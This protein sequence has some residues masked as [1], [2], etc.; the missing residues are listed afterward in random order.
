MITAQHQSLIAETLK[1]MTPLELASLLE[2]VADHFDRNDLIVV[3][4]DVFDFSGYEDDVRR[5]EDDLDEAIYK[6]DDIYDMCLT[7]TSSDDADK[8]RDLINDIMQK[9]L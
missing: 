9:T 8:L 2:E 6:L 4:K 5:L 7:V 1:S 3:I